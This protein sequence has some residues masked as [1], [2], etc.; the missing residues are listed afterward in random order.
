MQF[1]CLVKS[2]LRE[3]LAPDL[4][5][6]VKEIF[7]IMVQYNEHT[8]DS[9]CSNEPYKLRVPDGMSCDHWDEKPFLKYKGLDFSKALDVFIDCI[10]EQVVARNKQ[11]TLHNSIQRAQQMEHL[12][13][14]WVVGCS[15][16][17]DQIWIGVEID[18][19][20]YRTSGIIDAVKSITNDTDISDW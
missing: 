18:P 14:T 5:K 11:T 7:A 19:E 6:G 9:S 17:E 16:Y 2:V 13:G 4:E 8:K 20:H 12:H 3:S 1:D 15:L 10:Y